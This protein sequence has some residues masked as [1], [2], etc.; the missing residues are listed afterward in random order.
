MI[1]LIILQI[2]QDDKNVLKS[3]HRIEKEPQIN[4]AFIIK[5]AIEF[6]ICL[7]AISFVG[8]LLPL[9]FISLGN[10]SELYEGVPLY[11]RWP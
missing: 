2:R 5:S 9:V 10:C 3:L 1:V 4:K 11:I 6:L 8:V 7:T